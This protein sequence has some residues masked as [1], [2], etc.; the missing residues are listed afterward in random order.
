M[1]YKAAIL[2]CVIAG[3][4]LAGWEL[5]VYTP[6][7]DRSTDAYAAM[8]A[9]ADETARLPAPSAIFRLGVELLSDRST[10]RARTTKASAS[11]SHTRSRGS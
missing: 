2:S 10:T 8:L 9:G 7:T 1:R 6:K 3:I 5:A 4:C 11:S